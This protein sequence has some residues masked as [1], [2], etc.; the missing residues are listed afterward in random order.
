MR[1]GFQAAEA[2]GNPHMKV[3]PRSSRAQSVSRGAGA[4]W[5]TYSRGTLDVLAT[6]SNN[7]RQASRTASVTAYI[8]A[9]ATSI[10]VSGVAKSMSDAEPSRLLQH[11][12]TESDVGKR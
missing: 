6:Q 9:L 3:A 8:R 10:I 5:S 7:V 12:T 2:K 4:A 1:L 11:G